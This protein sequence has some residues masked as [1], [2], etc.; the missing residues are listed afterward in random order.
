MLDYNTQRPPDVVGI[1]ILCRQFSMFF[2]QL[3]KKTMAQEHYIDLAPY[4]FDVGID[5]DVLE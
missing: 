2:T 3:G 4:P 1:D 5:N